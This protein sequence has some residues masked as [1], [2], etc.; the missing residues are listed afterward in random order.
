MHNDSWTAAITLG[1]KEF[2]C[3]LELR[4]YGITAY[5]PV[6]RRLLLPRGEVKPLRRSEALF[7]GYVLILAKHARYRELRFCPHLR[8]PKYLLSSPE[9][10]IWTCP[11]DVIFEIARLEHEGKFDEVPPEI[12]SRARLK[13]GGVLSTMDLLVSCLDSATA[14]A[15][16]PLFGGSRTTVRTADLVKA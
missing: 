5:L 8:Q 3:E 1:G 16:S 7:K 2:E 14:Q 4:R 9:G 13:G 11:A 6:A 15:I 10:R 12:G